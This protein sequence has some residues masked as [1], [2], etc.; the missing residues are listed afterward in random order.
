[1]E[2]DDL[3]PEEI[4]KRVRELG[5]W[6]QNIE[7]KGV[8]T[9][10]GHFLGDY[11]MIKW[12]KFSHA[13]PDSLEGA[14]VLDV[15]CNAGFYSIALKERGAS[16][17]LGIDIDELYLEQ[18]RFAARTRGVDI[19]FMKKSVYEVAGLK[20][21]FDIVLFMGV[22]YHLRHPLLALDLLHEYAVSDLLVFQSMLRGCGDVEETEDDYPFSE[23]GVFDK[24]CFPRMHFMEKSYSG[25]PTNWWLPNRS[26]VEAMLRSSGFTIRSRPEEEV[27]ICGRAERGSGGL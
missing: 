19:E 24:P 6:F 12:R 14:T 10:P 22:L 11:P 4:E 3:T 20:E 15:G 26:C 2:S 27:Y 25:D 1:M 13:I 8:F 17:V 5:P 16:R 23:T 21:R 7:L 9:A 18:A